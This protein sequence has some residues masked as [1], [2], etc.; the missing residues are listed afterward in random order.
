V[1]PVRLFLPAGSLAAA[2]EAPQ[3]VEVSAQDGHYLLHVLRRRPGDPV[4]LCD[5]AIEAAARL[6]PPAPPSSPL[7]GRVR[8]QTEAASPAPAP[9][10]VQLTL[11][12]GLLKGEKF[13]LVVQKATELGVHRVVPL[14]CARSVP[15]L[16][17]RRAGGR[18]E[19]WERIA[20]AAAQQCRRP[21]LPE[22]A[23]PQPLCDALPLRREDLRLVF[24]EGA[25][26][27]S[28]HEVLPGRI[29]PK[30]A[31]LV[32]PEGGLTDE[33]VAAAQGAGF[34][35]CGLGRRVLRAETAALCALAILDHIA[36]DPYRPHP[37]ERSKIAISPLEL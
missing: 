27:T 30:V 29:P 19:R 22:I 16:D 14:C 3:V 18:R 2:M 23:A 15:V 36:T 13:D 1:S 33:E 32:G 34:V 35:L 7:S 8:L 5:G 12:L 28:L 9:P 37:A 21:D 11:L 26:G 17:E 24:S 20:R 31:L 25:M 6:L 4:T 10:P